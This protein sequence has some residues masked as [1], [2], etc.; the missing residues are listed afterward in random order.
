MS[1]T[2]DQDQAAFDAKIAEE[3]AAKKRRDEARAANAKNGIAPANPKSK[4]N[5]AKVKDTKP[6]T[7]VATA[8]S[9]KEIAEKAKAEAEKVKAEAEKKTA[10]I[11]KEIN[12]RFEKIAKLEGDANDHRLAAALRLAEAE[13]IVVAAGMKF[14]DWA[15]TNI[16]DQGYEAVRKL[17]YVGRADDP[18]L[19]LADLR[20]SNRK[21]QT[22]HRETRR[23]QLTDAQRA[24]H[25]GSQGTKSS[26]KPV[27]QI[28]A[29]KPE[30]QADVARRVA[31]DLGLAVVSREDA[32][33]IEQVK[34]GQGPKTAEPKPLDYNGV[35]SAVN[36]LKAAEQLALLRW[37]SDK[38]NYNILE[39]TE[40]QRKA[41][42][43]AALELPDYLKR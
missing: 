40:E 14:K 18:K 22:K 35:L 1:K 31:K 34:K 12:T 15:E 24:A 21:A 16:K 4:T 28:L 23:V 42:D 41:R 39:M 20:G 8:P 32:K 30:E 38:H 25:Q 37:L 7:A 17:L 2:K 13:K 5:V 11:A 19:A 29:L 10:P 26:T 6:G 9:K 33:V 36:G 27:D 43:D 3:A